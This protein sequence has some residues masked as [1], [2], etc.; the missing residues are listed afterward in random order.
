[1]DLR[2]AK[3]ETLLT[4]EWDAVGYCSALDVSVEPSSAC[5][6]SLTRDPNPAFELALNFNNLNTLDIINIIN[7]PSPISHHYYNYHN[8]L[9]ASAKIIDIDII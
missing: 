9:P 8:I 2:R 1:M 6:S 3:G 4:E 5:A 7:T